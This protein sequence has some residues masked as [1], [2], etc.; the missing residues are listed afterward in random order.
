MPKLWDIPN[1][2]YAIER[3]D[4]AGEIIYTVFSKRVIEKTRPETETIT[5][6]QA[7]ASF[8]STLEAEEYVQ[9]LL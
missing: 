1:T 4:I 2:E 7:L 3:F 5:S 6:Y 9:S 8:K